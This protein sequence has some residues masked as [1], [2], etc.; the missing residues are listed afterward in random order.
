MQDIAYSPKLQMWYDKF[1]C[2]YNH[3]Y[4]PGAIEYAYE[5]IIVAERSYR[6][7]PNCEKIFNLLG[8]TARIKK[9]DFANHTIDE[10]VR[11]CSD[12]YAMIGCEG[13]SFSN[14]I[15]MRK[16][17]AVICLMIEKNEED[18]PNLFHLAVSRYMEHD[19]KDIVVSV[20]SN[21]EDVVLQIIEC[22]NATLRK[23][24]G[25]AYRSEK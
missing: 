17:S 11:I 12:A 25:V 23:R 21:V 8:K 19:Y 1:L 22:L 2:E 13:A 6:N 16:R 3:N 24:N 9:V 20:N 7:V 10:Q 5:T 15:F 14:Q 4:M 18:I